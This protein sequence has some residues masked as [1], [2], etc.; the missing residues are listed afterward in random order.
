VRLNETLVAVLEAF[1][2]IVFVV[3]SDGRIEFRILL[4]ASL[5]L[6]PA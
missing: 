4:R 3:G 5:P 1:P 6:Q 2:D